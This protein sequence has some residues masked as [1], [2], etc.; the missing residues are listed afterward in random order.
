MEPRTIPDCTARR[1]PPV[2]QRIVLRPRLRYRHRH[3]S[4]QR[5]PRRRR[6]AVHPDLRWRHRS[7]LVHRIR[8]VSTPVHPQRSVLLHPMIPRSGF[9]QPLSLGRRRVRTHA[10]LRSNSRSHHTRLGPIAS[11]PWN[12]VVQRV[13]RR[14]RPGWDRAGSWWLAPVFLVCSADRVYK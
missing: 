9:S 1:N 14:S 13:H 12:V 8:S 6:L 7:R 11:R 10:R 2:A 3:R 4:G 5:R